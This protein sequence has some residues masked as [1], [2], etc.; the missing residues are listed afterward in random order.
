MHILLVNQGDRASK[1]YIPRRLSA[2]GHRVDL[3]HWSPAVWDRQQFGVVLPVR[4][5]DWEGLAATAVRAH[6]ADPFDGVLCYDEATVPIAND[7][8]R[9][10]RRPVISAHWGDAFR[11]KDRMRVAWEA[12]GLRVPRYRV[13]H[14]KT[15]LRPLATWRFPVVLKPTAMMGSR[16]V[17]KVDSFADLARCW[18]L[19]FDA[20]EDM[21]I[22]DELW[23]MAELFDIP[24]AAL[25]EEYI[26]GPEFSA[27]GVVAG[28]AYHLVGITAKSS[29]DAPYF[30]ELGHLFPAANLPAVAEQQIRSV[31][32]AA[33]R[34]LGLR[35][36]VTHTEFRVDDEGVCLME[37]NARIPGGH[38][39]ELVELVTGIDLVAAAALAACGALSAAE[40]PHPPA[41]AAP[42]A[43]AASPA[44]AASGSRAASAPSSSRAASAPASAASS[45]RAASAAAS[46]PSASRAASAA[47]AAVVHLTAPAHCL[48]TR[49]AALHIP[50]PQPARLHAT[51]LHLQPGDL[52][53]HPRLSGQTRLASAVLVA[54][55]QASL[56]TAIARVRAHTEFIAN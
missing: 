19:P 45:S 43:S 14:R 2:A 8:A 30:D 13:L 21:R 28:G 7:L 36:G 16:G 25:A 53:Q 15:D 3:I 54:D 12:V 51:H 48:G 17:V 39:P 10:L 52:I 40:L 22:G 1:Q 31:L 35:N 32:A 46:A 9:L 4:F 37:L 26:D 27:E 38:I 34:A 56:A 42:A 11:H 5:A 23:S 18:H 33:H 44:S 20:D 41:P 47:C 49:F 55:N 29:G 24:Q 50:D 6:D